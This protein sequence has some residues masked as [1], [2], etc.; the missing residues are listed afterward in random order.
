[1]RAAAVL[2]AAA[3]LPLAF[4]SLSGF[5]ADCT[6]A[7]A[8]TVMALGL[9]VI[10][11]FAGLLDLGYVAFFAIG[12]YTAGWLGST[13]LAGV[14]HGS[15][16]HV[17]ATGFAAHLPGVHLNFVLV[18]AAAVGLTTLAGV[19]IGVP[20]LR[21]RGDYIGIV[22]LAF[23]EII[24]QLAH[25][26]DELRIAGQ[27]LTAGPKGIT[28]IDAP[29]L[30]SGPAFS[31]LDLRP[32][33]WLA[34]ALAAIVLAANARL[35]DSRLGRAWVAVR[36]DEEVAASL[37]I[38]LVKTKLLAYGT[39]AAF[40]GIAGVFLGAFDNTVNADQFAFPFSI[41]ILGM[42]IVGGLGSIWGVVAGA[43]ALT[44][45]DYWLL[46]AVVERLPLGADVSQF[47]YGIYG[48]LLVIVMLLRPRG[49]VPRY[50]PRPVFGSRD[51]SRRIPAGR[52]SV[53][54]NT[55]S[56]SRADP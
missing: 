11:G 45:A 56:G 47:S 4:G 6:L 51:G 34:L 36:E 21:L 9:N 38:P 2:L 42:V 24:G 53:L 30:P 1:M 18:L 25:N 40:G 44:F 31:A 52:W 8:Y 27:P 3:A 33:Y 41:L 43:V 26:G 49:L 54:T 10:V 50:W 22:T 35:R 5:V 17:L 28:P 55:H 14:D 20:T 39:G 46:P 15:G 16:L 12:A 23:G 32:W 13:F 7:L 48:F 19:A 29:G 37:G